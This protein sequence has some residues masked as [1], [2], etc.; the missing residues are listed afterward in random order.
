MGVH[1]LLR[2]MFIQ[3]QNALEYLLT[4]ERIVFGEGEKGR[5]PIRA[6]LP[7]SFHDG[8]YDFAELVGV[9]LVDEVQNLVECVLTMEHGITSVV[10]ILNILG[11]VNKLRG[12]IKV[13]SDAEKGC[14][15]IVQ[16]PISNNTNS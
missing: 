3:L 9:G 12:S 13:F 5:F 4:A 14:K 2:R 15:F 11:I 7:I 6:D 8:L 1:F 10:I 16:L